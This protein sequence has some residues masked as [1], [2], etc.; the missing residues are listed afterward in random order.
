MLF[1]E[2]LVTGSRIKFGINLLDPVKHYRNYLLHNRD[3]TG[4]LF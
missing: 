4:T 2:V 1:F 3:Q